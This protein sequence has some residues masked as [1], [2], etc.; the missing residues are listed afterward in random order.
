MKKR[1]YDDACGTA[2]ALELVGDRW[3]LLV[4]RELLLGPKRFSDLRAGLPG[5]S[6]NVLTQ[7]LEDL[8]ASAVV[9]RRRLPPPA[10]AWVY[11]LTPWGLEA[12]EIV[13]V[14]GRWAARSPSHDPTLPI[15]V[16]ST[17]MSM[18]TM[19][20]ADR[21]KDVSGT[22]GFRLGREEFI[23]TLAKGKLTIVRGTADAADVVVEGD[24]Q[25]L[26]G[27]IYG[28]VPLAKLEKAGALKIR[29]DRALFERYIQLFPLPPKAPEAKALGPRE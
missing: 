22:I 9:V 7:R 19:F 26:A 27:A 3:A 10:S 15:S 29:G 28:G 17:V 24:Q 8:E 23:A 18:R 4:I 12:E 11:E 21:A 1:L 16:S 20:A 14:I 6:A 2:H 5:I 25:A 13:K